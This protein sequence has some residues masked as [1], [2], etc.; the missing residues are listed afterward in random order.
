MKILR[1]EKHALF[2]SI[3]F[4][5]RDCAVF[6]SLSSIVFASFFILLNLIERINLNV[7][8]FCAEQ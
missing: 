5:L 4:I 6:D 1:V 8:D 3:V 7:M 2:N